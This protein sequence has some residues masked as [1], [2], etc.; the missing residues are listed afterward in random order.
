MNSKDYLQDYLNNRLSPKQKA[1]LESDPAFKMLL[2]EWKA[3]ET[4]ID[5]DSK[6]NQ[7]RQLTKQ[8][9]KENKRRQLLKLLAIA[10]GFF[11]LIGFSFWYLN[12]SQPNQLFAEHYQALYTSSTSRNALK[13][14]ST[15]AFF[16]PIDSL[17]NQNEY[18]EACTLMRSWVDESDFKPSSTYYFRLAELF[19]LTERPQKALENLEK[20]KFGYSENLIWLKAWAYYNSGQVSEAQLLFEQISEM[21]GSFQEEARVVLL[22]I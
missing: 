10:A 12:T 20:V 18:H 15:P 11:L 7:F 9:I 19:L 21:D 16:R 13:E 22:A 3:V 17:Y 5:P 1:K 2:D 8:V 6:V 14:D 4:A